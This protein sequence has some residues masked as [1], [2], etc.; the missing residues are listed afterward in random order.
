MNKH[1]KTWP[2]KIWVRSDIPSND[3]VEYTRS[4]LVN[5]DREMLECL[6]NELEIS[7]WQCPI[8]GHAEDTKTMD[9]AYMLR[10]YLGV[11]EKDD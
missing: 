11:K 7:S 1:A 4:D 8:C 10:R 5:Q 2:E 6:L 9:I 3:G